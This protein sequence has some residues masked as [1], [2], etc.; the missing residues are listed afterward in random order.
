MELLGDVSYVE[1]HFFLFVDSVSVSETYVH[2][3]RQTYYRP[4]YRFGRTW[5][6][7][8]VTRLKWKAHFGLFGDSANLDARKVHGLRRTYYRFRNHF[9][10]IQWNSSVTWVM[11][12]LTYFRL[13]T[14]LVSVQDRCMVCAR[15]V[16]GLEIIL[17]TPDGTPRWRGSSGSLFQG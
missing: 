7:S 13:E 5:W 15:H 10:R 6:Y 4:R 16:V 11:W 17:D 1:S 9:G 14:V 3:L 2:D 8:K 12:N